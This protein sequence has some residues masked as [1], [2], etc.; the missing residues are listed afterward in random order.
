MC[1]KTLISYALILSLI[2]FSDNSEEKKDETSSMALDLA[3]AEA[4][5][6][7]NQDK[8]SGEVQYLYTKTNEVKFV[9]PNMFLFVPVN[10][11]WK[12]GNVRN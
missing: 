10:V 4:T 6:D 12:K 5:S 1:E 7:D 11:S 9:K 3:P 8:V 2:Y